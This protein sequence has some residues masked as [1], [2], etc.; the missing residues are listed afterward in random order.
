MKN[1]ILIASAKLAGIMLL[2][3]ACMLDSDTY[4]P[5]VIVI[6]T[7]VYLTL[8]YQANKKRFKRKRGRQ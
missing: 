6:I 7:A 5:Y 2:L 3:S 4:I 1:K 8:F